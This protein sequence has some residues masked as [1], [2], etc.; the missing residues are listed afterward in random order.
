MFGLWCTQLPNVTRP[1][2]IC[3][4]CIDVRLRGF[5]VSYT[6]PVQYAEYG[7]IGPLRDTRTGAWFIRKLFFISL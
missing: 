1:Q 3:T 4:M 6:D 2:R 5:G 7:T